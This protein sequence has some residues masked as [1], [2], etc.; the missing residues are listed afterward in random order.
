MDH[1]AAYF[2]E[3]TNTNF[4]RTRSLSLL[5]RGQAGHWRP[6]GNALVVVRPTFGLV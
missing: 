5:H 1:S 3:T 6:A 4:S 2:T